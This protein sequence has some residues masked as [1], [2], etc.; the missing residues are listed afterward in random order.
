MD[1]WSIVIGLWFLAVLAI[2][3]LIL[4]VM[5]GSTCSEPAWWK[6]EP[7]DLYDYTKNSNGTSR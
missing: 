6:N 2:P 1:L 4:K 3:F 5:L 7:T